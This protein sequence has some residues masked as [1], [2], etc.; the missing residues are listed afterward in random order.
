MLWTDALPARDAS[1][2]EVPVIFR[3]LISA[4]V[5]LAALAEALPAAAQA[6]YPL[7]VTDD[8]GNTLTL[9]RAPRRIVSLTIS[10]D[11]MLLSLVEKDRLLGVTTFAVDRELSNVADAAASIPYKLT[12]NVETVISL[13]PD[14]VLVARWTDPGLVRQLRDA[15][16]PVF[17]MDNG[18]TVTEIEEKITRLARLVGEEEKGR[19][20]VSDMESRLAAVAR[21]V[22][23]VAPGR[24]LRV[25]DYA[26]WG[27]AQGKGSSWDEIV[28]RAGCLNAVAGSA[29]DAW[30]QVPLSREKVLQI[31]PDILV[32]PGWVYGNPRGAAAFSA[33]ITSDPAFRA[34]A[35]V[36]GGHVYSMPEN[37][38]SSTS[39][40]IVA[41]VEWLAHTA[42]PA[43][44]P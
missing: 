7:T 3:R 19:G 32:L 42:Y 2:Q 30:G 18:L 9:S 31:D 22:A 36:R 23:A 33:R 34:L 26:T 14:L 35:A 20:L 8:A 12:L 16:V 37:L 43:L 4:A 24:R 28:R 44:F 38:K 11:E 39:Q 1:L 10:T 27:S 41:A 5:L 21:A 13:R 15:R 29:A 40:Y 25:M 17:L 6:L